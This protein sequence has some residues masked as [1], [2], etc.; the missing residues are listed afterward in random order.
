MLASSDI[1]SLSM[2]QSNLRLSSPRSLSSLRV[3][4]CALCASAIKI[5]GESASHGLSL[6][7]TLCSLCPLWFNQ[8]RRL[9]LPR[10]LSSLCVPLC[11]LRA[12]AIKI[13]GDSAYHEASHKKTRES[14][15]KKRQAPLR[16]PAFIFLTFRLR[17]SSQSC[18]L[19]E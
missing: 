7:K 5:I 2:L 4:L 9:C 11:A 10:S 17:I 18:S 1:C 3:P 12:S 6:K 19:A 8:N 13:I 16:E 14:T 15:Q